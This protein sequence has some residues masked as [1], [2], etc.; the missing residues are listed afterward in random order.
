MYRFEV[1]QMAVSV[2]DID[3]P[4]IDG[5][6]SQEVKDVISSSIDAIFER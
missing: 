4:T 3:V 5:F 6:I 2:G 1:S